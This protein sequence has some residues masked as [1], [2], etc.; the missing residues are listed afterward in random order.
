VASLGRQR[1][2]HALDREKNP[3]EGRRTR[4]TLERPLEEF[5][6]SDDQKTDGEEGVRH[7]RGAGENRN[8]P[9][10]GHAFVKEKPMVELSHG[11]VTSGGASK[12]V[13]P[14]SRATADRR[15][16]TALARW[17]GTDGI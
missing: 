9:R 2:E 14:E 3:F 10:P 5:V 4:A 13:V 7:N 8:H 15:A 11:T 6:K 12:R 17:A 16:H 1:I